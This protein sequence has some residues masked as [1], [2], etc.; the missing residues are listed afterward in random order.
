MKQYGCLDLWDLIIDHYCDP[1]E[2]QILSDMPED[3]YAD[4]EF[5]FD[6]MIMQIEEKIKENRK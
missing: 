1:K 4:L 3:E 6:D 2:K 5:V